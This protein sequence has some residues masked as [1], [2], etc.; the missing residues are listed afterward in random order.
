LLD[1]PNEKEQSEVEFNDE[2][3]SILCMGSV[4]LVVEEKIKRILFVMI[5]FKV[6]FLLNE[7]KKDDVFRNEVLEL[8][9][10]LFVMASRLDQY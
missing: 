4:V 3:R 9:F 1:T 7:V 2:W 10:E 5:F 8:I 6:M